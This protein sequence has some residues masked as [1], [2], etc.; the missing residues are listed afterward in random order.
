[1]TCKARNGTKKDNTHGNNPLL[2]VVDKLTF[3][4]VGWVILKNNILQEQKHSRTRLLK[5]ISEPKKG[6]QTDS[7]ART[8]ENNF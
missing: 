2:Y 7:Y 6:C 4:G 3:K 5:T 1:M 8:E